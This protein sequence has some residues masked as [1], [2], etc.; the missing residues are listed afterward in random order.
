[1]MPI[2]KIIKLNL[3]IVS[4]FLMCILFT[5]FYISKKTEI[6]DIYRHNITELVL[7]QEAMNNL[8]FDTII[9]KRVNALNIIQKQ[10]DEKNKKLKIIESD[11]KEDNSHVL[12][13]LFSSNIITNKTIKRDLSLLIENKKEIERTFSVVKKLQLQKL[14]F[15]NHFDLNYPNE[16]K[17]RKQI[18]AKILALNN[19]KLTMIFNA[20]KYYSKEALFQYKDKKHFNE[21]IKEV[22]LLKSQTNIMEFKEYLQI[23]ENLDSD[24][25]ALNELK[26]IEVIFIENIKRIRLENNILNTRINEN[27]EN[28]VLELNNRLN[29]WMMLMI[30]FVLINVLILGYK[31]Y[32]NIGFSVD[33]MDAKVLE[34]VEKNRKKDEILSHQSKL[35]AMGEM[36]GNIAHQWRQP[37]NALAG[38]V[39]FLRDDFED[40]IVD[41][42]FI[43]DFIKQNMGF[44]NFMSK[45]I[46]D[47]R[48]F[49]KTDKIK[50]EFSILEALKQPVGILQPQFDERKI[51]LKQSGD[52]FRLFELQSELEQVILNILNNAR[53]A[54]VENKIESPYIKVETIKKEEVGL[55]LIEDNAKGI[56]QD[57]INKI[58]E[59][60]FTTK[61]EGK[62]TGIG[63]YMSSRIIKNMQGTLS[64]SNNSN[65]AVFAIELKIT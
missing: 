46:D 9:V 56:P 21:W 12:L 65:G 24:I 6:N 5:F 40:G 36:M 49:F 33:E 50:K 15:Q 10:F 51:L 53:D 38:N 55:I 52:D 43:D 47:F 1:M 31:V 61:E 7:L 18:G 58:F 22:E 44:I 3:L 2:K 14:T 64:V 35:A 62:G 63:L 60:Y 30:V 29:N 28:W 41:K 57:V 27:A 17:V 4:F 42:G 16:K 45:T 11:L 19:M 23:I 26:K 39:Q 37:L 54:L 48:H 32:T 20:S 34:E 13:K 25:F 8:I 59:P